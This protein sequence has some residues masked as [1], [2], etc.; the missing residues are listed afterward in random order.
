MGV[1]QEE[2]D[3]PGEGFDN[4][5]LYG[6]KHYTTG[7]LCEIC[8]PLSGT[9]VLASYEKDFY[10]GSPVAT[11]NVLGKGSCR[12]IA[13]ETELSFLRHF[14]GDVFAEAGLENPLGVRLPYGVTAASRE[15]AGTV[16]FVMNFSD[17]PVRLTG[18]GKWQDVD[19]GVRY[20]EE[21]ELEGFSCKILRKHDGDEKHGGVQ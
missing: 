3:A 16:T 2:I 6:G 10:E 17:S 18:I 15:G 8:R 12:Y 7:R 11:R 1:V 19:T 13:A 4:G 5:F 14:Y 21:L 9:A 20:E